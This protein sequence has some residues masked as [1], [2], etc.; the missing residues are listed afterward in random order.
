[1]TARI[2][3]SVIALISPVVARGVAITTYS[4]AGRPHIRNVPRSSV[5]SLAVPMV[6]IVNVRS[7]FT[8][9]INDP[10]ATPNAG[11]PFSS[12]TRP[13]ITDPRGRR[14]TMS[15]IWLVFVNVIDVPEVSGR[16]APH[17]SPVRSLAHIQRARLAVKPV[18]RTVRLRSVRRLLTP[19]WSTS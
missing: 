17:A 2:S 9:A 5:V 15:V 12:T 14:M 13:A 7:P 1:M 19:H 6:G 8:S 11:S 16:F 10:H 4:P 3:S 18:M